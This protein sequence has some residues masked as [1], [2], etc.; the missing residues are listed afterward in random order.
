MCLTAR[1]SCDARFRQGDHDLREPAG[2]HL[3]AGDGDAVHFD[4][5]PLYFDLSL[6][7]EGLNPEHEPVGALQVVGG[8]TGLLAVGRLV[9]VPAP[10]E[11][12]AE[13][14]AETD[15]P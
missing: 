4:T 14:A 11:L 8:A 1:R 7:Q 12:L 2:E 6:D 3:V 10:R 15:A 13:A 5:Q 9:V